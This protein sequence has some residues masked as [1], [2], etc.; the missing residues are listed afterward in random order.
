MTDCP[1]IHIQDSGLQAFRE[2]IREE[3]D[4]GRDIVRFLKGAIN[5][6]YSNYEPHHELK[7][8]KMLV[9]YGS[10]EAELYVAAN[11]APKRPRTSGSSRS[12]PREPV[13]SE[14]RPEHSRT[15]EG[16]RDPI[17]DPLKD[18]MARFIRE[19]TGNGLSIVRT[20]IHTMEAREDPYKPHHNLEAAKQLTDS[21]FP[22]TSDLICRPDCTHH[23]A[24]AEGAAESMG[25][26]GG[27][28]EEPFDKE[29]WDG[30][31]A[32]LKQLEEDGVITPDPNPPKL[33]YTYCGPPDDYVIPPEV[34]AEEAAKFRADI[35]LRV[36]R[37]K[38]W[39][40]IEE[41]RRKKLAQIYP[42]HSDDTPSDSDPPDP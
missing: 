41:R 5:R 28:D 34:A 21:G 37:Q 11:T 35:A 2:I 14:A 16:D 39:P 19:E 38:K 8:A 23:S 42:S 33:N 25:A 30:I 13:Q 17:I 22:P 12:V 32:E 24:P 18:E 10:K 31:I 3:T 1:H 36:E 7:A 20:L 4:G 40:E 9:K 15:A 29:V 6:E 27:A 26:D